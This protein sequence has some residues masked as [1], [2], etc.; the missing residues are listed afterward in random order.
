VAFHADMVPPV[1]C[2]MAY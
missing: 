2:R 1:W